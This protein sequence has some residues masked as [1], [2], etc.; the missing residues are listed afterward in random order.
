MVS[1]VSLTKDNGILHTFVQRGVSHPGSSS[2]GETNTT[3]VAKALGKKCMTNAMCF[4]LFWPSAGG[5]GGG[6]SDPC[7]K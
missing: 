6:V 7:I 2:Y 4:F 5:G 3:Y 1:K